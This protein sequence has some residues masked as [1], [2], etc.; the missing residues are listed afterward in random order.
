MMSERRET[1]ANLQWSETSTPTTA[2]TGMS[3]LG[4]SSFRTPRADP[5]FT[6]QERHL[7]VEQQ[8]EIDDL[9]K[10][11]EESNSARYQNLQKMNQRLGSGKNIVR[12]SKKV[13]MTGTDSI[14]QVT[15]STFLRESVWPYQKML[16]PQWNKYRTD[17]KSMSQILSK[18]AP[19]PPG[20]DNRTY[21]EGM[22]LGLTN[23][24]FCTFRSN[25]KQEMFDQFQGNSF[26]ICFKHDILILTNC[27]IV[28]YIAEDKQA[29][30]MPPTDN[31]GKIFVKIRVLTSFDEDDERDLPEYEDLEPFLRFIDKYVSKAVPLFKKWKRNNKNKT[32]LDRITPSD[33]AYTILVFEN[34]RSVWEEELFIKGRFDKREDRKNAQRIAQPLY[35]AGRG[36][37]IKK[38]CD[39]WTDEGR[40][41]YKELVKTF[42]DLKNDEIWDSS[43][44]K[45]WRNY[46]VKYYSINDNLVGNDVVDEENDESESDEEN[47]AIDVGEC[48]SDDDEGSIDK[49][50]DDDNDDEQERNVRRRMS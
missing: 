26:L 34:S 44:Q 6:M 45:H 16:P 8:R 42:K 41:Y 48:S 31:T 4:S 50:N 46:Q 10:K 43:F 22:L 30:I 36:H 12:D 20:V 2:S 40:S 21:W 35:H 47:W 7:I 1:D 23:E 5:N 32:L 27:P 37:R 11:L 18:K 29:G 14:N 49:N 33:I 9:K 38:Y 13:S 15:L 39:G 3:T 25:H 17:K 19:A 24:K 28:K